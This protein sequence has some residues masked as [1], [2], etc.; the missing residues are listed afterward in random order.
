MVVVRGCIRS[1]E[2]SVETLF[3]DRAD[4]NVKY[5]LC[6]LVRLTIPQGIG[7]LQVGSLAGAARVRKDSWPDQRSA[8][9]GQDSAVEFKSISWL[10]GIL[11][12]KGC[13]CE[14]RV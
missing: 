3:A 4:A 5:F 8:H 12:S 14:S 11:N 6:N 7:H 2:R 10:D 13:R 1:I 9:A